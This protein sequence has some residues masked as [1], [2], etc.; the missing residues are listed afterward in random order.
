[1]TDK[2]LED[3]LR[4][5][6]YEVKDENVWEDLT[7]KAT[8]HINVLADAAR[9]AAELQVLFD[10]QWTRSQEAD[11]MWRKAHPENK[12]TIP[13][14]G[15]LLEWLMGEA[16]QSQTRDEIVRETVERC[17]NL[18]EQIAALARR[19]GLTLEPKDLLALA[20]DLRSLSP[21]KV[22]DEWTEIDFKD[23]STWPLPGTEVL[24]IVHE[25]DE[26]YAG[27]LCAGKFNVFDY[28]NGQKMPEFAFPGRSTIAR[29]WR[30]QPT[31]PIHVK[32]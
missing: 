18:V 19:G 22:G 11:E 30:P 25:N 28:G 10:L 32:E 3:A 14:L 8:N 29:H 4:W 13:D 9:H 5:W 12:P 26:D 17:A 1:M 24:F 15:E 6:D 23:P 31:K 21:D 7:D 27:I 20:A 2:K 16:R